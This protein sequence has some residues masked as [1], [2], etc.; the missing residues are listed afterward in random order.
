MTFRSYPNGFPQ[1]RP[2]SPQSKVSPK[3]KPDTSPRLTTLEIFNPS[4]TSKNKA[5]KAIFLSSPTSLAF[6]S[7]RLWAEAHHPEPLAGFSPSL[8]RAYGRIYQRLGG[9]IAWHG[10]MPILSP[11]LRQHFQRVRAEV[12]QG[13]KIEIAMHHKYLSYKP[14]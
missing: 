5:A 3:K 13:A 12:A 14:M 11:Q 2:V 7:S 8:L 10:D 1:L 9:D 6:S 4:Q